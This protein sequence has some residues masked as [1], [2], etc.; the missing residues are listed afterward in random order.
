MW[1][2]LIAA[3]ATLAGGLINRNEARR[4][5]KQNPVLK[6][7]N[8]AKAAGVHPLYAL[9]AGGLQT[10]P[11][12]TSFG[13][14]VARS[15]QAIGNGLS[16]SLDTDGR[17]VKTLLLEKAGLENELLRTQ[18]VRAKS[19]ITNSN[20]ANSGIAGQKSVM[21]PDRPA[22]L[23]PHKLEDPTFTPNLHVGVPYKTNPNFSDAQTIQN[24]YGELAESAYGAVAIPADIVWNIQRAIEGDPHAQRMVS[25][26]LRR[27]GR[28]VQE[29]RR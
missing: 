7:V 29:R 27:D 20:A 18:I 22:E 19:E 13:D 11:A 24:R 21:L 17:A 5:E 25:R 2:A 3:G 6:R 28:S 4:A 14:A 8:D 1:P 10:T 12:S 26:F 15:G 9:G 16:R 23:G